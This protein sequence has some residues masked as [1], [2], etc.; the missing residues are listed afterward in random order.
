M[1]VID[2]TQDVDI[3]DEIR[4]EKETT[5]MTAARSECWW[6]DDCRLFQHDLTLGTCWIPLQDIGTECGRGDI[7][8][9]FFKHKILMQINVQLYTHLLAHTL[10]YVF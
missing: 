6:C 7:F 3:E 5:A 9:K 1:E 8:C 2:L 4:S 10:T